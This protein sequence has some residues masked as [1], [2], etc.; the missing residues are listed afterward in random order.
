MKQIKVN[1]DNDS[2]NIELIEKNILKNLSL[3]I[4]V[5]D[6][7][8]PLKLNSA[9]FSKDY[10]NENMEY[11]EYHFTINLHSFLEKYLNLYQNDND[12]ERK[13][14]LFYC[15]YDYLNEDT[16]ELEHSHHPLKIPFR[17]SWALTNFHRVFDQQRQHFLT[18]YITKKNSLAILIDQELNPSQYLRHKMIT[19]VSIKEHEMRLLG[20]VKLNY[21]ELSDC[22]IEII[23]RGG[24]EKIEFP[25]KITQ[26]P[27]K[28]PKSFRYE[29]EI[30][31]SMDSLLNYLK[32]LKDTEDLSLDLFF[33][34]SLKN[35]EIPLRFRVGN[36]KFLTN[37]FMKGEMALYDKETSLWYSL[38]PYTT[39]KA[40]NF[41]LTFNVYNKDAY[42]YYR[43]NK[44]NWKKIAKQASDRNIWLIGER[45]YKAQDNGFRFFKYLRENHPEIEAYYVIR[46]DSIERK[47]V[48]PLG[49]VIFTKSKEHFEKAIQ[50]KYICGTHHPHFLYPIRSKEY[51]DKISAK[52][53]FLQHGV[54]GTK[55]IAKIYGK[56]TTG[57][58]TDLFITSSEKEKQ[59]VT[60][61]LGYSSSEVAVTGLAR[62]DSLFTK[63]LPLKRQLLII[64]TWRDWITNDERFRES[65]YLE[66]YR[67][68]L[69]DPRLL[70]FS[71]KYNMKLIFCL[72]PNMQDY[73]DYFKDAPVTLISQ[74][75]VDVQALIKESTMMLT[76][77]SSVAFDF[78]FLHKPVLYYQF[79]RNRFL[80]KYPSHLDLDGELPG[81]IVDNLDDIFRELDK[82]GE[83]NFAM[84][85]E[86]IKKADSFIAY[87]DTNS[88]ERIYNAIL[89]ISDKNF[90]QR[91]KDN[92]IYLRVL[93][94]FRR[95]KKIYFPIMKMLYW[96]WSHFHSVKNNQILFESSLGKRFEDSPKVIYQKMV[97]NNEP[98]DYVWVS[99]NN[100]PLKVNPNTKII[101]RLSIKYY[102]YLATSKYWVNNQN[103]PTYLT[104]RKET[105]YLQT[106]HGTPLKKMQHDQKI[107]E[108]R[109]PG[110]LDRVTHAKNQWTALVSPSPYATKA[111]RSAFK[112]TG[113][114]IEKG[115]P[116]NDI[117]YSKNAASIRQKVRRQLGISEQK[118]VILYAPTFR[119]YNKNGRRFVMDNEIDF[120]KFENTLG[121]D[122]VLLM[123]QHVVIASRLRIP[124]EMSH[125]ILNVSKY[126]SVQEL[127]LASDVLVTDYSSVMFDYLNTN[128]PIYFYTYDLDKYLELRGTYF[129][130]TKEVPGPLVK[131]SEELFKAIQDENYWAEYGTKYKEFQKKFIPFDGPNTAESIYKDF[132]NKY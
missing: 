33:N 97:E 122:Y 61:D 60:T 34:I 80:G 53:V 42:D 4:E 46:E 104:K 63:D 74:G 124:G 81:P 21:F 24:Q 50:A 94:R 95:S 130:F 90:V 78:S 43:A 56:A 117:F 12:L 2:I 92:P 118:K 48:D 116:R 99:N 119:D 131:T 123:R 71:K 23:E 31:I 16:G 64:P 73:L 93:F 83:H 120:T 25:I 3:N 89:N 35:N 62:F 66:R 49:N 115:Y 113:P 70:S 87:R 59:I 47:N 84:A 15:D 105:S 22:S 129:D 85:E 29:Y 100:L 14:F 82:A 106:W 65:E 38:I 101:K 96:Y 110:Y 121:D 37:Y 114:I 111:F 26:K 79:D 30:V 36:P 67:K 11:T 13:H 55:N 75:E 127:M 44:N 108:G 86:F 18:P 88:C 132:L 103:F 126:P 109:K 128:K 68:L 17:N 107:I 91:I 98:F 58:Q 39:F 8:F 54:L 102:Y 7:L 9:L 69:F 19:K 125:N 28:H 112:Y 72:H 20:E 32:K 27:F 40:A 5:S 1:I 52:K 77:Y 45:S 10:S 57:F 41:S 6:L 76:D 51:T